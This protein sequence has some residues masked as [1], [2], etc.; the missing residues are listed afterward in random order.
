MVDHTINLVELH[1]L[2]VDYKLLKLQTFKKQNLLISK[3]ANS[4]SFV[5]VHISGQHES[6]TQRDIPFCCQGGWKKLIEEL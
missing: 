2:T 4:I 1:V 5:M 3:W 6:L